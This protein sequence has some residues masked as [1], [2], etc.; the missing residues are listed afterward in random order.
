VSDGRTVTA[1]TPDRF[2]GAE[3]RGPGAF[4]FAL[5]N[6]LHGAF[7]GVFGGVVAA[8]ALRVAR[9]LTPGRV[10]ASIDVRFL[11]A[12]AGQA[13]AQGELVHE[14]R[15][16]A[17]VSVDLHDG[18]GRVAARAAVGLVAPGALAALDRPGAPPPPLA[19]DGARDWRSPTGTSIP[20]VASLHPRIL[21]AGEWGIATGLFVPWAEGDGGAEAVCMAA[22]MCVGPPVAA[23][24]RGTW[25]PHPNPD[26]SLRFAAVQPN[27]GELVGVGRLEVVAGGLA[28]V[29][30]GVWRGGRLAGVGVSCSLLLGDGARG[31]QGPASETGG[32]TRR[33]S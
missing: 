21:G 28:L 14:G 5:G 10:P 2:L 31:T 4:R 12:L 1:P 25:V 17:T 16:L 26:L 33:E 27:G 29:R 30:I 13:E 15:S 9:D 24:L 7:G 3:R 6:H 22:D 32:E 8:C 11:R 19:P 18:E 20:I 23:A